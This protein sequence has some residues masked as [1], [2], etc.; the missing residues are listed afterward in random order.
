MTMTTSD[1]EARVERI[2][3]FQA[4]SQLP[5]R[6]ARAIDARDL[7]TLASLYTPD[8]V[9]SRRVDERGP[10]AVR[11][12]FATVLTNFYRSMHQIC[13]H[14]IDT[15]DGD[16]ASGTVYCRVE[17]E[18]ADDWVVQLMVY[19][20]EYQR[21]D[22][23]WLIASR[24]PTYLYTADVRDLPQTVGFNHWPGWDAGDRGGAD[25]AGEAARRFAPTLPQ[26]WATW[27][28]YWDE[29]RDRVP[30]RTHR[31]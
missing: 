27:A 7:D 21:V 11:A 5:M 25:A 23:T 20:D 13:G 1:L 31:P 16:H 26:A 24:R 10:Q 30:A 3:A 12:Y 29:H 17:H 28:P 18:D 14:V 19:F 4:I 9:F 8:A 6:Y 22:G 15:I 2:E